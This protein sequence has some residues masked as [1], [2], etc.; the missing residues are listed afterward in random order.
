MEFWKNVDYVSPSLPVSKGIGKLVIMEDNESVIKMIV[1]Q[2][3]PTMR[4]V[5]RTHRVDLD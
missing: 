2:R 5:G 1:K 4:H 3:S